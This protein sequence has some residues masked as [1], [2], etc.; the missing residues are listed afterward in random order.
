MTAITDAKEK[1]FCKSCFL[2][3][4]EGYRLTMK[5]YEIV[6]LQEIEV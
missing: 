3:L 2:R 5:P 6:I 4:E 1:S